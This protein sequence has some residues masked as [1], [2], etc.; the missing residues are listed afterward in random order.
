MVRRAAIVPP[1]SC[2]QCGVVFE[3]PPRQSP[4]RF[5]RREFCSQRCSALKR[6]KLIARPC[7]KCGRIFQPIRGSQVFCTVVC[8][9]AARRLTEPKRARRYPKAKDKDGRWRH[10][11]RIAMEAKLGR[12]LHPWENV[13]HKYGDTQDSRIEHLELWAVGQPSG[14]RVADLI[15]FVVRYYADAVRAR[16]GDVEL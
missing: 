8:A 10:V 14:Q 6:F 12:P 7:P 11:H 9:K 1:R 3:R 15:D 13:H 4:T 5:A 16:F 2:A